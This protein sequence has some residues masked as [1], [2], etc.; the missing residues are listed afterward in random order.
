MPL[1]ELEPPSVLPRGIGIERPFTL[2][3]GSLEKVQLKRGLLSSLVKPAGMLIHM[4]S[5]GGPASSRSTLMPGFSVSR[6]ARTQPAEPAP[7][8]M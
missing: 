4:E 8:M 3:S 6:L 2:A 5:S 7:T 1:I